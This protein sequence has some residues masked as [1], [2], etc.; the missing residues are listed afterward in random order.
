VRINCYRLL[1]EI[2]GTLRGVGAEPSSSPSFSDSSVKSIVSSIHSFISISSLY[3]LY[4]DYPDFFTF[5]SPPLIRFSNIEV[6]LDAISFNLD[7][8]V[9]KLNISISS[10]ITFSIVYFKND[11]L[12]SLIISFSKIFI[13]I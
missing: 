4:I 9:S 11:D 13:V 12:M 10:N 3:I 8:R 2:W 7:Q 5:L 1:S 6:N